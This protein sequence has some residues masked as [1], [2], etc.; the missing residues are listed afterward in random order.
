MKIAC[1]FALLL[2]LPAFAGAQ[3]PP[4]SANPVSDAL[5]Q[6]LARSS[7]NMTA[8]VEAMPADKFSFKPTADQMSFAHLAM[9][10]AES[11]HL[12]CAKISGVAAP[13]GPKLAETDPKEKLV[14]AVKESFD[15]CSSSL[16]KVDD[17][18]LADSIPLFNGRSFS[19][20]A[21]MFILS[22]SWADHYSAQ[23]M[24]LRLNGVL[25]PTAQPPKP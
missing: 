13:E 4:P 20:A 8:A 15:F 1:T 3:T 2:A 24:Y 23:S 6:G 5:R 19:R 12:F 21:V 22:G 16:A 25:P 9:H 10:I 7:K 14:A 17:S 18:R 11:N